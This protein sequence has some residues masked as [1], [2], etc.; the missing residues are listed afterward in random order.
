MM[1]FILGILAGI[2]LVVAV[3]LLYFTAG[4]A[5]A[6]TADPPMP[7]EKWMAK[8]ALSGRIRRE[9]PQTVPIAADEANFLSGARTYRQSCAPC[10]GLPMQ[11]PPMI[12]KNMFPAPPQFFQTNQMV[13]D[14]PPGM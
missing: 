14:D 9:M 8:T 2:I 5:P 11:S 6:G 13:V 3:V 7:F 12:A 1:K 4:M 10:H